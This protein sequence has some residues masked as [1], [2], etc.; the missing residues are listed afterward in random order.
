MT[1]KSKMS[2]LRI[3][4]IPHHIIF[5]P[6]SEQT[7]WHQPA[8]FITSAH[9]KMQITGR[10]YKEYKEGRERERENEISAPS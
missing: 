6:P 10:K 1:F 9:H 5:T 7:A 8:N 3:R 2:I 4:A